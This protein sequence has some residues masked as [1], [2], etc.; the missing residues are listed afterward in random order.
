M[1]I[2]VF[3]FY[4]KKNIGD[5]LFIEAFKYLFS[6]L[7]F[8]FTDYI[9]DSLLQNIDVV[10]IGGGSFL[11]SS[12]NITN[13]SLNILKNKKIFYI[14]VGI[15]SEIHPIHLHLISIAQLVATRSLDQIDKIK[16]LNYNT[17]FI[18]DLVYCL[19]SKVKLQ[20]KINKS[21]LI[22]P[23]SNLVPKGSDNHW[24]HA[25]WNYFKSEFSQFLDYLVE[26]KYHLNFLSFCQSDEVHDNWAASEI[27]GQMNHRNNNFI[28][29]DYFEK[30]EDISNYISKYDTV[31]TQRF[32]GIVLS[33]MTRVPYL[34]I[35]HHDK[36]KK[37]NLNEGNFISYYGLSKDELI[38]S[39]N[40]TINLKYKS[41][42]PINL[43]LF[44][45]LTKQIVSLI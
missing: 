19:Q 5:Q 34:S 43:H 26:Q 13:S 42:L 10:F 9:D 38:K 36:L 11:G 20:N 45:D 3:G 22:L 33:E 12:P 21:V 35:S 23:N 31:I 30:M 39:F 16:L 28:S 25:A 41:I 24:K 17:Y 37:C 14:G 15:E 1:K 4:F 8:V 40:Q 7:E 18:P 32:H 6:E 29:N 44:K 27:I 2:L